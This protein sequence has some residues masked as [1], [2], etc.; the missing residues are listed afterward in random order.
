MKFKKH[1][2]DEAKV[3]LKMDLEEYENIYPMTKPER[4][5]LHLWVADGNSPYDNPHCI[6]G[7]NGYPEDFV[8]AERIMSDIIDNMKKNK[9]R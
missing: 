5:R 2:C 4:H 3:I 9:S 7:E 6:Y 1:V 8:S